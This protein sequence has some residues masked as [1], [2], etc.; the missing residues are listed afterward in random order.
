M[1][2]GGMLKVRWDHLSMQP[3]INSL[4]SLSNNCQSAL[5]QVSKA[6]PTFNPVTFWLTSHYVWKT[7][8]S[9]YI[10]LQSSF[11][12]ATAKTSV[13][14]QQWHFLCVSLK[15]SSLQENHFKIIS[16]CPPN[17]LQRIS[18]NSPKQQVTQRSA[19]AVSYLSGVGAPRWWIDA[20][21]NRWTWSVGLLAGS[22]PAINAGFFKPWPQSSLDPNYDLP[23]SPFVTKLPE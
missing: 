8:I 20:S 11:V 2:G 4:H 19:A 1:S 6:T 13:V 14:S 16:D 18:S 23:W 5:E 9:T 3:M 17:K 22:R 15:S 10:Q 7:L 12:G 21:V